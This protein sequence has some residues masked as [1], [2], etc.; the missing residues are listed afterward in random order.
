[1][2]QHAICTRRFSAVLALSIVRGS[3]HRM[4]DRES[5]TEH[6][7]HMLF[8]T[9]GTAGEETPMPTPEFDD[10]CFPDDL[11]TEFDDDPSGEFELA[12]IADDLFS[13]VSNGVAATEGLHGQFEG[14]LRKGLM[15]HIATGGAIEK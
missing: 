3:L 11:E 12:A 8:P 6:R 10:D 13:E 7:H 14:D 2:D 5:V 4:S 9:Q 15:A 1:M